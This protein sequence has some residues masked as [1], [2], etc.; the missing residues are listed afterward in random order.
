MWN[1]IS[2]AYLLIVFFV[3]FCLL[4]R[5]IVADLL[6]INNRILEPTA[7]RSQLDPQLLAEK[8]P[9][10]ELMYKANKSETSQTR[11]S[12]T[13]TILSNE[14]GSGNIMPSN[15]KDKDNYSFPTRRISVMSTTSNEGGSTASN[16]GKATLKVQ[17]PLPVVYQEELDIEEYRTKNARYKES[18]TF[19][20]GFA[21]QFENALA[22][23]G[24]RE[25]VTVVHSGVPTL[26][27]ESAKRLDPA[28]NPSLPLIRKPKLYTAY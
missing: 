12:S 27:N 23:S 8:L 18:L 2:A 6:T 13:A 14:A 9:R 25:Y 7:T 17:S 10:R 20:P 11:R 4:Q 21:L 15:G 1:F 22:S 26:V 16:D 3:L 24:H 19:E 5:K 28:L